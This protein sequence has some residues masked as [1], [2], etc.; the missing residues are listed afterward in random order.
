MS[1][2]RRQFVLGWMGAI[3][4]GWFPWGQAEAGQLS[5]DVEPGRRAWRFRYRWEDAFDKRQRAEFALRGALVR[6]DLR[7]PKRISIAKVNEEV[8]ARVNAEPASTFGARVTARPNGRQ[9][10]LRVDGVSPGGAE[11][12][13]QRARTF[14]IEAQRDAVEARGYI[15]TPDL[16]ILPDH[17]RH[18]HSYARHMKPIVAGL[19]GRLDNPRMFANRALGFV[20]TIPYEMRAL[21]QDRYRL[22]FAIL[23]KNKGDCDSKTVLYLAL[24]RRAWPDVALAVVYVEG[25]AFAAL[26]IRPRPQDEVVEVR[27]KPYVLVE[28]V[29]PAVLPVGTI[30]D[31]SR[32]RMRAWYDLRFVRQQQRQDDGSQGRR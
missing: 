27:G 6:A 15:L 29:G 14:V 7:T 1:I 2:P 23:A 18:V 17:V 5:V 30:G 31:T 11:R 8:I 3:G 9:I 32:Q 26:R 21:E 19:G 12:A 13:L 25:H 16:F 4:L 28:P 22:P 10:Q 24:M 20:Q